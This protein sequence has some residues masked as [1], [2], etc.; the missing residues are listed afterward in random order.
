MEGTTG[1]DFGARV[2]TLLTDPD[3][4]S[5]LDACYRELTGDQRDFAAHSRR[6]RLDVV[7]TLFAADLARLERTAAAA[8]IDSAAHELTE[9]IVGMPVYRVYPSGW[10]AAVRP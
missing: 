1:Y 2:V 6:A 9:L 10:G 4:L 7:A 8:G 3:G 5:E